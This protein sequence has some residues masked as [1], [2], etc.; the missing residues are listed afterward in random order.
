MKIATVRNL[1]FLIILFL[2][3]ALVLSGIKNNR[4]VVTQ[5]PNSVLRTGEIEDSLRTGDLLLWSNTTMDSLAIQELTDGPYSHCA[6]IYKTD[7]NTFRVM[8]TY[9]LQGLRTMSLS[10]YLAPKEFKLTRVA[11]LRYQGILNSVCIQS[12]IHKLI[13]HKSQITFDPSMI[14]E[15]ENSNLD[16]LGQNTHAIYCSELVLYIVKPCIEGAHSI[17]ENDFSRVMAKWQILESRSK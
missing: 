5:T 9:P 3:I 6:I 14:L 12:S 4:R 8:D 13:A 7:N 10:E 15:D 17:Y 11:L 1:F 2:L 16:D